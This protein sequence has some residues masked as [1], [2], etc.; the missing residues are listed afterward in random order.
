VE[1]KNLCKVLSFG[2]F[3]ADIRTGKRRKKKK[4]EKEKILT[5][6]RKLEFIWGSDHVTLLGQE[7]GVETRFRLFLRC[8]L[9]RKRY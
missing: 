1:E 4:D 3:S 6:T 7:W 5:G 9:V 8:K 2:L